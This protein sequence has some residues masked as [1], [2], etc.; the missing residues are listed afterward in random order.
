[1]NVIDRHAV[2]RGATIGLLL[3]V[4]ISALRVLIDHNVSDFEHS[5]WAPLFA[6]AIFAVYGIAGFSAARIAVDAPYSNGIVAAIGAFLLW[7]PIRILIWV[8]RD[9][10]QH[11]LSGT[12]PVFTPARILG[13]V[14]FAAALGAIGGVIA[15]RRRGS[16]DNRPR[17]PGPAEFPCSPKPIRT[18]RARSCVVVSPR[19]ARCDPGR[20]TGSGRTASG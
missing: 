2:T 13:Q 12:A 8:V 14:V 1:M 18:T 9:S 3:F 16:E 5:G 10:D 4:P 11:L 7:I 20:R 17:H 19:A 15:A 6:I